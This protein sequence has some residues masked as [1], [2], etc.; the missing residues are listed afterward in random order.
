MSYFSS[1]LQQLILVVVFVS[2]ISSI[3][4]HLAEKTGKRGEG[5]GSNGYITNQK[6]TFFTFLISAFI[7]Q[8][9][10]SRNIEDKQ[11]LW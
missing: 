9:F 7:F 4:K 8:V 5:G 10:F 11:R 2:S 3:F 1:I 6:L